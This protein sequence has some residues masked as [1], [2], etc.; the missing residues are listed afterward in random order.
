MININNKTLRGDHIINVKYKYPTDINKRQEELL[1]EF[2]E[3]EEEKN[4]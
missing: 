4:N 2:S 1:K 3:I